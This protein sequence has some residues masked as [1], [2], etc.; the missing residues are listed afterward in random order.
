[1]LL[2]TAL[3]IFFMWAFLGF[4]LIG[5]GS[6]TLALFDKDC[7]LFDAFWMGLAVSVA[8][9]EIWNLLLPV[10]AS[11]TITLI[12]VGILGFF[13]NRSNLF[14]RIKQALQS[15]RWLF[16][17][18]IAILLLIALRSA[19]PCDYYDTGL[20]GASAVRWIQSYPAVPGLANLHGRLG[21]NSSVFLFIAALQQ[22]M[23]HDLASHLFA[24]FMMAALCLSILPACARVAAKPYGS[25]T[26]WFHCILAIPVIFW[27]TRSKIVGTLTDEPAA[28]VCLVAA[29]MLFENFSQSNEESPSRKGSSR[30][31]VAM[32]LFSLAVSFKISTVVFA[33]LAWCLAFHRIWMLSPCAQKRIKYLSAA[34]TFSALILL[35]WCARGIILSG[36]PLYPVAILGFPVDWKVP[37]SVAQY[38]ARGVQ[39]WGR[40]PDV[41]LADTRGLAW[42]S[43]WLNRAMRNRVA[44]Q[45][46]LGISL[47][48]LAVAFAFRSG[49]KS[50]QD[51]PWLWLLLPSLASM[52]F[53]FLASPDLRFGQ[54]AIW[55]AAG[56]LGTEGIL[57]AASA[58]RAVYSRMSLALLLLSLVWCLVS[59][60]WKEPYR[61]LLAVKGL[62]PLPKVDLSLR[63]TS[64]GLA[65]YVPAHGNQCWDSPIPCTPYFDTTLRLRIGSSL[66][67]GFASNLTAD[68]LQKFSLP[69]TP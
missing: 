59:F 57:S 15:P 5:I 62:P 35:P 53:W 11:T 20:Y 2:L 27:A 45:V 22:G 46:P 30:L 12:F 13:A 29:G 18:A 42:L 56:T 64:S 68:D 54:F 50:R 8:V 41:P 67:S 60:G 24:G 3:E 49:D 33:L 25:P 34:L 65:V 26:D 23:W 31:L 51:R 40:M 69:T 37:L 39:S 47:A 10:T 48:G 44:F 38:Y 28:I 19:G 43:E 14:N 1:M 55:T 32:S 6:A 21:F 61:S 66:R 7:S 58:N 17:L 52:V 36:Y 4:I 9:L 16:L 63:H